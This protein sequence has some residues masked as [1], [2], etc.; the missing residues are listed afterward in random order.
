[1][2]SQIIVH[3]VSRDV[4]LCPSTIFA[5]VHLDGIEERGIFL[6]Q[7]KTNRRRQIFVQ[8]NCCE[9]R[10]A[11]SSRWHTGQPH[12]QVDATNGTLFFEKITPVVHHDSYLLKLLF[13]VRE[14]FD[15]VFHSIAFIGFRISELRKMRRYRRVKLIVV[16]SNTLY[17]LT[18]FSEI[19]NGAS[20]ARK[21]LNTDMNGCVISNISCATTV[22]SVLIRAAGPAVTNLATRGNTF[23]GAIA[24]GK[25]W[26]LG[27]GFEGGNWWKHWSLPATIYL[28]TYYRST[29]IRHNRTHLSWFF[30]L[31][32]IYLT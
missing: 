1:M 8:R 23:L 14:P 17:I 3:I 11:I 20:S 26:E 29:F 30:I 22:A 4:G 7:F 16:M 28:D 27:K 19:S 2:Q 5:D 21:V 18:F 32:P 31:V 25:Y 6:F 13:P 15:A 12:Y 9:Q 10:K 24:N